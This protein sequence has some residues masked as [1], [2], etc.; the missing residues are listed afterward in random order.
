MTIPGPRSAASTARLKAREQRNVTFVSGDLPVVW[1]SAAGATVSDVDG[2]EYIDCTAA[3]GVAN[4][5]HSNRHVADAIA[6]Q[7]HRLMHGM[8]DVH[9][10]A[11]KIELLER[12]AEIL[13]PSLERTF[14]ATTGSEAVEAALK[15]A[16]L[17][18]GKSR[19]AAFRGG[20]HGLSIGALGVAGIERFRAPFAALLA[21]EPVLL[22]FPRAAFGEAAHAVAREADD[23]LGVTTL[24]R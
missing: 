20:Y 10:N 7:A 4:T 2:N 11:A 22:D 17:A 23:L 3:F 15:T 19:F 9:P 6:R 18:T 13:P 14:L 8:G 12:L 5:G 24:P 21:A 16:V 1:E